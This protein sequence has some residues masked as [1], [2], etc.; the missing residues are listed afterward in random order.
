MQTKPKISYAEFA[1]AQMTKLQLHSIAYAL[2]WRLTESRKPGARQLGYSWRHTLTRLQGEVIGTKIISDLKPQDLV[3]HCR[4]RI[5]GGVKPGT[6][7]SDITAIRSTVA[8]YIASNDLPHAWLLVFEK[9]RRLLRK[10]QLVG[11][12]QPRDR[13]PTLEELAL[14]RELYAKQNEHPNTTTDMVLVQDGLVLTGRR[15]SELARI[16]RQHVNVE[17]K[18][19]WV[20]NLK[21]SKGKGYH[22]EAALIEG[23]WEL[24]ERRLAE[25][26]N[27]PTARLFPVNSKTC[28]QRAT[29]AKKALQK[30][31]PELFKNLRMHDQRAY[32]FTELLKKRYT[33]TQVQKGVSLHKNDKVLVS[34]YLRIHAEDLHHGPAGGPINDRRPVA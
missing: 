11:K 15:I 24:F 20:Y 18:T 22:G 9:S 28:S 33:V 30:E 1:A 10:E 8:D 21:N 12:S 23:A 6:V 3:D 17:K 29:K 2:Q 5:A 13:L 16:E 4:G 7:N 34:N 25:I 31:H 26:P 19:Y 14:F 27:E 32:C